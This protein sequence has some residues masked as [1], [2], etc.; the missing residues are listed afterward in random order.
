[1]N[2]AKAIAK[3]A[4]TITNERLKALTLVM[5]DKAETK[6]QLEM[7]FSLALAEI[8]KDE[9][10]TLDGFES[11]N[12]YAKTVLGLNRQAVSRYLFAANFIDGDAEYPYM[13]YRFDGY[14]VTAL[15]EFKPLCKDIESSDEIR[16]TVAVFCAEHEIDN[17]SSCK[18]IR[19]AVENYLNPKTTDTDAD[20][21]ATDTD[22]T[23]NDAADVKNV[24]PAEISNYIEA[25]TALKAGIT[26]STLVAELVKLNKA[27]LELVPDIRKALQENA[28][29]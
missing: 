25:L 26:D 7:C 14:G 12:V 8:A 23:N 21:D 5:S 19:T 28:I 18:R 3:L 10:Y 27:V 17:T 6:E 9:L 13:D 22:A 11:V 29:N 2:N 16:R 15:S 4:N 20:D 24:V 1:M